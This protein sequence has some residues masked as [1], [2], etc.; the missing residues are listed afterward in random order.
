MHTQNKKHSRQTNRHRRCQL[1]FQ[2]Y[3]E[4]LLREMSILV[5]A[6]CRS[7]EGDLER[8]R[9]DYSKLLVHDDL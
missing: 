9:V 1:E 5:D 8:V 4:Q 7:T 6:Y 2:N 3:L